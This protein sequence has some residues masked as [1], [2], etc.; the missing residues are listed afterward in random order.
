MA[1]IVPWLFPDELLRSHW[2]R[3]VL[4]NPM[5]TTRSL[6]R[7]FLGGPWRNLDLRLPTHLALWGRTI[8]P[9]V[10]R[11]ALHAVRLHT[12]FPIMAAGLLPS[13]QG[14][15]LGNMLETR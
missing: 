12:M 1:D 10:E 3:M 11:S 6:A 7:E 9:L 2:D 8:G 4:F 5:S 15:V 14:F 13:Q